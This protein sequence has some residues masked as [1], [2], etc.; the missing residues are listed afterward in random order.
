MNTPWIKVQSYG[1]SL[2]GHAKING[3]ETMNIISDK[4]HHL[5][6]KI[7]KKMEIFTRVNEKWRYLQELMKNGDIYICNNIVF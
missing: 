7:R 3:F 2:Y 6:L 1:C 4:N 5:Y